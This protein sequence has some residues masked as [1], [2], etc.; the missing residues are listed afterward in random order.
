[1][2]FYSKSKQE[3]LKELLSSKYGLT[4]SDAKR[5]QQQSGKNK[6]ETEKKQ[7]LFSKF[8]AQF[9]DFMVIILIASAVISIVIAVASKEYKNLFE[10]GINDTPKTWNSETGLKKP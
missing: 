2:Q 7:S 3:C 8:L 5:R 9:K 4:D 1:M 6:I 10:G